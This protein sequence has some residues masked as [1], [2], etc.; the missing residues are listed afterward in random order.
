MMD[1]TLSCSF[2]GHR[3]I[4]HAHLT[5]LT[6]KLREV[7]AIAYRN[8]TRDFFTGG[9]MGFDRLAASIVLEMKQN[10][11]DVRLHLVL[12]C[13]GQEEKWSPDEQEAYRKERAAADTV[14]V[15]SPYYYEGCMKVRNQALIDRADMC[16]AY[17]TNPRSGAG[18]TLRMAQKYNVSCVNLA[19][20]I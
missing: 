10:H 18:Q 2:T 7:V 13:E 8:G 4:P 19:D 1:V 17:V 11:P 6:E 5:P 15:L 12:P 14:E 9:A 3:I 16:V 20:L